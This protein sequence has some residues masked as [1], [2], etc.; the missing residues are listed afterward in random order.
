MH[1][2]IKAVVVGATVASVTKKKLFLASD[3]LPCQDTYCMAARSRHCQLHT[4]SP[5]ALHIMHVLQSMHT[6]GYVVIFRVIS[7]ENI[8]HDAWPACTTRAFGSENMNRPQQTRAVDEVVRACVKTLRRGAVDQMLR[9]P[10]LVEVGSTVTEITR[11]R[12]VAL[13]PLYG[14]LVVVHAIGARHIVLGGEN[15]VGKGRDWRQH[16]ALGTEPRRASWVG[17]TRPNLPG[18][19]PWRACMEVGRA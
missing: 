2:R 1:G 13:L 16:P 17:T 5:T 4:S 11:H 7:C 9:G 8:K 6:H 12:G 3:G 15:G 19:Y 14:R 10:K 18:A